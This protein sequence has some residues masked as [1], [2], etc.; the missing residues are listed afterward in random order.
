MVGLPTSAFRS[1]VDRRGSEEKMIV[2]RR[3]VLRFVR[4]ESVRTGTRR[5]GTIVSS[6]RS[7][8]SRV[9]NSEAVGE[10]AFFRKESERGGGPWNWKVASKLGRPSD[11]VG[12]RER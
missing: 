8:S 1:I 2:R 6:A 7:R 9:P 11:A 4:V 3:T 5:V 12:E 10:T